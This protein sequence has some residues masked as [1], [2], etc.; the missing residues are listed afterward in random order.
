[1]TQLVES[2]PARPSISPASSG[3]DFLRLADGLDSLSPEI[4][5]AL[6]R[7]REG[8]IE[9]LSS[10]FTPDLVE[11]GFD[12]V[13]TGVRDALTL[14]ENEHQQ[15]GASGRFEYSGFMERGLPL[16]DMHAGLYSAFENGVLD[17]SSKIASSRRD[18][19][20]ARKHALY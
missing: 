4:E 6:S 7:V 9:V 5:A 14:A 13:R 18:R 12:K 16:Q 10:D 11:A 2:F 17:A 19:R 8:V 3:R 1:M 20:R 15:S